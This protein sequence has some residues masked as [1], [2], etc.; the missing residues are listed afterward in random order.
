MNE[1]IVDSPVT[2]KIF[3]PMYDSVPPVQVYKIYDD[4]QVPEYATAQSACF[5]LRAYLRVGEYVKISS[6]WR[7]KYKTQQ[8]EN[9]A[10]GVPYLFLEP[11]ETA[12][13]PTGLIFDIKPGFS[14]RF[15]SRSGLSFKHGLV[16]GNG[17]GVIDSDYIDESF[18]MIKNTSKIGY[19]I[20]HG[21]RIAQ[22]EVVTV[23]QFPLIVTDKK[24][25]QK[26]NRD[27]GFGSTGKI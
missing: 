17:E 25:Q 22:G 14:I 19:H 15:H 27:G 7:E 13:I 26:T 24:P 1:E 3:Y 12:L 20:K 11:N 10:N 5:D 16:L 21:E 23:N 4:A 6:P 2:K 9:I 18:I 8:D